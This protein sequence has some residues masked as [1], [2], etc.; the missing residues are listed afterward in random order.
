M[1]VKVTNNSEDFLPPHITIVVGEALSGYVDDP[2]GFTCT[3][4]PAGRAFVTISLRNGLA[5]ANSFGGVI[6]LKHPPPGDVD[7]QARVFSGSAN[8]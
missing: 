8:P 7:L 5:P 6:R 4:R 3:A 1:K 2:D